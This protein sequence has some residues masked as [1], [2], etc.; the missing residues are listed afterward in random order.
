MKSDKVMVKNDDV[1]MLK[2][3]KKA[4]EIFFAL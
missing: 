1:I 4:L 3:P 2:I